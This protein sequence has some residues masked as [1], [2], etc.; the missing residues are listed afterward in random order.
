MQPLEPPDTH[1]LL[2]A[3][4]WLELGNLAEARAELAQISTACQ[5]HPDVLEVRWLVCAEEKRWEEGL[6][7]AR[8]LL[9][10]APERASGWLHQAYA[11]RRVPQ[12]GIQQAWDALLPAH[13]KFPNEPTIPYNLSCYACQMQQ[14]DTARVWFKRAVAVGGKEHVKQMALSDPDLQPLWTEIREL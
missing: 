11:L 13:G 6:A 9:D 14:L 12:G 5:T 7:A 1:A 10:R 3:L 4:G 2:A 8:A